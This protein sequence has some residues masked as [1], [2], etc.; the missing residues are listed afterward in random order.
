[1]KNK[2][3]PENE[4]KNPQ[5][6]DA[7]IEDTLSVLK[8]LKI[9][10]TL[11]ASNKQ[12][13]KE[14]V[15]EESKDTV[16]GV[17]WLWRGRISIPVPMAAVILIGF[18]LLGFLEIRQINYPAAAS[19]ASEYKAD[20]AVTGSDTATTA[21]KQKQPFYYEKAVYIAGTGFV[22]QECGYQFLEEN[23]YANNQ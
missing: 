16:S 22:N 2:I 8:E 9:P 12:R 5:G 23:N 21:P 11:R 7:S 13:I 15:A 10:S 20:R 17:F 19:N 4:A 1:M 14:A 6:E 18:C 3:P